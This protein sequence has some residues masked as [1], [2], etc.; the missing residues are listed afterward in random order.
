LIRLDA[1]GKIEEFEVM[2][3]PMSGLQALAAEMG[4]RLA[5]QNATLTGSAA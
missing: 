3:R 5:P 2:V 4:A 1:E